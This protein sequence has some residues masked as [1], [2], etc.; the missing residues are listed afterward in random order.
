[1][2]DVSPTKRS[3]KAQQE[4]RAVIIGMDLIGVGYTRRSD[5]TVDRAAV[6]AAIDAIPEERLLYGSFLDAIDPSEHL[7]DERPAPAEVRAY[8]KRGA[9]EYASS[10]RMAVEYQMRGTA[11]VFVFAGG[12]S[13]GD[14]PFDGF[15]DLCGF[16]NLCE[17]VDAVADAAGFVCGGLPSAKLVAQEVA[18]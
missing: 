8:L 5:K 7:S 9:L 17:M 10:H 12:G 16:V 6:E 14:D 18:R 1:M 3:R 4:K 2:P 13:W 15:D 11:L